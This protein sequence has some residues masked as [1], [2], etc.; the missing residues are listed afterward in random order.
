ME[1][2]V[3]YR[4]PVSRSRMIVTGRQLAI[5]V[6]IV[7]SVLLGLALPFL[8]KMAQYLV[9]ALV[10]AVAG[11]VLI[12]RNPYLGVYFF[13]LY[14]V[15]RPYDFLPFLRPLR[16]TMLIEILTLVSWVV[17]L[18]VSRSRI[19]WSWFHTVFLAFV[20]V[21]GAT[22]VSAVNNYYAY[23]ITQAMAIYLLMFIIATNVVTSLERVTKIVWLLLV[24]HLY[25]AVKGILTFV[26]GQ[27]YIATT[28]QYTSGMVGGGFI[29]DENDFAMA[30]NMMI[31]FVFFG[32]FYLK[33]K[34]RLLSGVL[35]L[36]FIL[37]VISSF[38]RGGWVGLAAVLVYGILNVR[39]KLAVI[40]LTAFLAAAAALF[41]PSQYWSEVGT[42]TDTSESTANARLRYWDAGLRMFLDYPV[43]GVGAANGGIHMPYYVYGERNPHTQW[44]R[45]FHGVWIQVLAELGVLGMIFYLLM[46]AIAFRWLFR[47][48]K[49]KVPDS[50]DATRQYLA[51][52]M[53]GSLIGYFACAS[54]L[55]TAYYPHLWTIYILIVA[56]VMCVQK[57]SESGGNQSAP[58]RVAA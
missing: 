43:I 19:K 6:L 18:V 34:T 21:I 46:I 7:I 48:K 8:P 32:L 39:R 33:G 28:G 31:P 35:L 50:G 30:I 42:V 37:A 36:I 25:F 49:G 12:L 40:V 58:A 53:I 4:P 14:S 55:S 11:F 17:S 44:G 45:A 54:F 23:Q 24:I 29:G 5:F 20:A 41:A 15:L 47:I 38:S 1:Q 2:K 57:K 16:L 9:I 56:F 52:A 51:N 3:H 13:F 27:H 10:P 26:T 22:V